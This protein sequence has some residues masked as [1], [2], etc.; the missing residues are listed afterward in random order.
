MT[1][2]IYVCSM[3][4]STDIPDAIPGDD[5]KQN[6]STVTTIVVEWPVPN[7]YNAPITKYQLMLCQ[8]T[9]T[10]CVGSVRHIVNADGDDSTVRYGGVV[11]Y[12]DVLC[13]HCH[14]VYT[15]IIL[16]D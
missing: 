4:S 16:V 9:N 7:Y 5:I 6:S 15:G 14:C 2:M 10:G 3:L 11:V 12:S 8:K 1:L 13:L